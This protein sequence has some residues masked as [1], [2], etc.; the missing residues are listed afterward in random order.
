MKDRLEFL[1]ARDVLPFVAG[2]VPRPIRQAVIAK[3][4]ALASYKQPQ[5][6]MGDLDPFDLMDAA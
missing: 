4:A 2:L 3:A 5:K 1:I 6:A